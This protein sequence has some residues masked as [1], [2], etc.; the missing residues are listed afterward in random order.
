MAPSFL[1]RR[2][3][4]WKALSKCARVLGTKRERER[5]RAMMELEE[6]EKEGFQ[7]VMILVSEL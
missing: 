4:I 7:R 6:G 2:M 5:E 1:L 3:Q